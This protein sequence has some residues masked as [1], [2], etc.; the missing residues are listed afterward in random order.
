MIETGRGRG[1]EG[2]CSPG[3]GNEQKQELER[4]RAGTAY[5]REQHSPQW[6]P[7]TPGSPIQEKDSLFKD[8]SC[9]DLT[10]LFGLGAA[11][12]VEA[13]GGSRI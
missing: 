6:V 4:E 3:G 10:C 1:T 2:G 13:L 8:V 5:R 12:I 9:Q 7:H 11:P